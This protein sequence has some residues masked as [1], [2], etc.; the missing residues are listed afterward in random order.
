MAITPD[1]LFNA[2]S[3][4]STTGAVFTNPSGQKTFY[5]GFELHNT[6]STAEV[7]ELFDVPNSSG[8]VGTATAVPH[9]FFKQTVQPDETV[10][11]SFPANGRVHNASNDTIQGKSTT[12]SKVNI[13]P[14]GTK[15]V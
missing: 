8:S 2:T 3:L 13:T 7:V 1:K 15:D 6:N 11:V 9:R 14:F 4:P 5:S 10:W 12:A